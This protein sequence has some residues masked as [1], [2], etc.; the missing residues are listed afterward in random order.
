MELKIMRLEEILKL[1]K[2]NNVYIGLSYTGQKD[3]TVTTKAEILKN[4]DLLNEM[5]SSIN[6]FQIKD[7]RIIGIKI[8]KV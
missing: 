4:N 5:V 8:F 2:D 7:R 3:Y 6:A 1:V